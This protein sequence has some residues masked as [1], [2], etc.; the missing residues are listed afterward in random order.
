MTG[1]ELR[2]RREK[3]GLTQTDL[4][5]KMGTTQITISRWERDKLRIERPEMLDLALKALENGSLLLIYPMW[6]RWMSLRR[7]EQSK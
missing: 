6:E 5:S 2:T 1:D 3:L 7:K 4:A